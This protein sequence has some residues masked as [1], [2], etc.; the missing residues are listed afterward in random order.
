MRLL[1]LSKRSMKKAAK[2]SKLIFLTTEK[3]AGSST[4]GRKRVAGVF[5]YFTF[6]SYEEKLLAELKREEEEEK[7]GGKK[8]KGGVKKT[9]ELMRR[10]FEVRPLFGKNAGKVTVHQG[11]LV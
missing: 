10:K 5:S 11:P 2:A 6:A 1:S 4:S 8:K 9:E 7:K 3:S